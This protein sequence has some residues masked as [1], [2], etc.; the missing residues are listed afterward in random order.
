MEN[1]IV[2]TG[3]IEMNSFSPVTPSYEYASLGE[4]ISEIKEVLTI[5]LAKYCAVLPDHYR[6]CLVDE[7]KGLYLAGAMKPVIDFGLDTNGKP[8]ASYFTADQYRH[9][10]FNPDITDY[11]SFHRA[12]GAILQLKSGK[13]TTVCESAQVLRN[14]VQKTCSFNYAAIWLAVCEVWEILSV[15]H[16]DTRPDTDLPRSHLDRGYWVKAGSESYFQGQTHRGLAYLTDRIY[17]FVGDDI[18]NLYSVTLKN[19]TLHVEK[20]NDFRIVEYYRNIFEKHEEQR[21]LE[22]GF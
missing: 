14:A 10:P 22:H 1:P 5:D 18:F 19:T 6:T 13:L 16:R 3:D 2:F 12:K 20:G 8:V 21:F 15:L 4:V 17:E 7:P 11:P 9:S